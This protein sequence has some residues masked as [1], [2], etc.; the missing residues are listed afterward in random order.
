MKNPVLF[1]SFTILLAACGSNTPTGIADKFL[2]CLATK[3]YDRAMQYCTPGAAVV[4]NMARNMDT[5]PA[6]S[7]RYTVLRD[8]VI[9]DQ[10][11]VFYTDTKLAPGSEI[12][13]QMAKVDGK[14]KVDARMEK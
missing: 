7:G 4:V 14:W 1:L 10:G 3:E 9:G 5:Q 2:E 8:S 11:W 6:Q 13:M 12:K